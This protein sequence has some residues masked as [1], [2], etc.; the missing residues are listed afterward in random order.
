VNLKNSKM[1][2]FNLIV[3]ILVPIAFFIIANVKDAITGNAIAGA[4]TIAVVAMYAFEYASK[5]K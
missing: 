1:K 2:K 4:M 3:K 5:E